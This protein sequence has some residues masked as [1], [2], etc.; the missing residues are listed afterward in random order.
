VNYNKEDLWRRRR[1]RMEWGEGQQK[2]HVGFK[3]E[4]KYRLS[5]DTDINLKFPPLSV[6]LI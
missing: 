6:R 5:F 3:R 1:R 4:T 2:L